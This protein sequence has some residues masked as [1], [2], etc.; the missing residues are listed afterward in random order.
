MEDAIDF[1]SSTV[2]LVGTSGLILPFPVIA[3]MLYYPPTTELMNYFSTMSARQIVKIT[4]Y[5]VFILYKG[6]IA[7]A[8]FLLFQRF[9][10]A[11]FPRV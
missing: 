8:L 9:N 6:I 3:V 5:K 7:V 1:S 4:Q 2:C 10:S 11:I